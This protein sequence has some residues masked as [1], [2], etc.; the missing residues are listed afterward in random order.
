MLKKVQ[1][2]V[3]GRTSLSNYNTT[4]SRS[5]TITTKSSTY[6]KPNVTFSRSSILSSQSKNTNNIKIGNGLLSLSNNINSKVNINGVN[7]F[8]NRLSI[9]RKNAYTT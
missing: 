2:V 8:T 1:G 5:N 9:W 6:L 7:G 3:S 4:T